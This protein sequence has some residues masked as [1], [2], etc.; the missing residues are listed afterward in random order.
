MPR[1]H[2]SK[3][4]VYLAEGDDAWGLLDTAVAEL[5]AYTA[6][7]QDQTALDV[8]VT[9][10]D[11]DGSTEEDSVEDARRDSDSRRTTPTEIRIYA[12]TKGG[13]DAPRYQPTLKVWLSTANLGAPFE[14]PKGFEAMLPHVRVKVESTINEQE[15]LGVIEVLRKSMESAARRAREDRSPGAPTGQSAQAAPVIFPGPK[16]EP[17]YN[18]IWLVTV[19]GGLIVIAVA[20]LIAYF[21]S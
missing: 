10:E 1:T 7:R 3:T 4:V 14:R 12:Y 16:P 2:T 17:W 11:A 18:H 21:L 19:G 13:P 6:S 8:T 9:F 15:A 20:A 5:V